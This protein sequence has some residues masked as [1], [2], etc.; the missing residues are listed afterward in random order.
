MQELLEL[1]EKL[2]LFVLAA[3]G[4]Y[5]CAETQAGGFPIWLARNRKIRLRH[6]SFTLLRTYDEEFARYSREWYTAI[7]AI[8]SRHQ[9]T[10][11]PGGCVLAL[12]IENEYFDYLFGIIPIG[13]H[14]EMRQLSLHARNCGMTV[15]FFTNDGFANG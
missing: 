13:L 10:E 4:P 5:I 6:S 12:Q 9:V 8:I 1:C 2:E 7:L 11:K 3:V 15:P 14:D